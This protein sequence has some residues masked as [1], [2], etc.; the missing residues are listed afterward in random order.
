MVIMLLLLILPWAIHL[1]V[2]VSGDNGLF[3]FGLQPWE[4][5]GLSGVL[6]MPF[7][8]GGTDHIMS[9]TLPLFV[10]GSGLFYYY[11][12]VSWRV[13]LWIL[14]ITGVMLWFIGEKGSNHIGASGLVYGLVAFHLMSGI[15]RR[16]RKL[17]AFAMLVVFLYGGFIWSVFPGFFPDRN[18][19]WEGHLS[20]MASG[21]LMAWVCRRSGPSSDPMPFED[22]MDDDEDDDS[23]EDDD[24]TP[25]S[26]P[27]S[28]SGP[29]SSTTGDS[30]HV[31]YHVT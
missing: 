28:N 27:P 25:G 15:L 10:L 16:S 20:G 13:M 8:H 7:L 26:P 18:I 24:N 31:R 29:T 9:N 23:R 22:E 17:K 5:S 30:H 1:Y 11:R 19:S 2:L 6:F 12:E 14:L 4:F 21:I 3:R